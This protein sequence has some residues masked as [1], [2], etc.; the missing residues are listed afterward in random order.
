AARSRRMI[1]QMDST[2]PQEGSS[3]YRR[4]VWLTLLRIV[5]VTLLLAASAVVVVRAE[6]SE[7]SVRVEQ[8]LYAV[9]VGTYLASL[10]YLLVLRRSPKWHTLLAY[11]Q[12]TGDVL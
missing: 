8:T 1:A 10:G 9:I 11:A 3:L 2:A 4:L 7:D 6:V 5:L 12:V